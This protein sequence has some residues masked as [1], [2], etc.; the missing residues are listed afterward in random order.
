MIGESAKDGDGLG[1]AAIE[2]VRIGLGHRFEATVGINEL[3][4]GR[5]ERG[6][7]VGECGEDTM[8]RLVVGYIASFN[9][10]Q[11]AQKRQAGRA[12]ATSDDRYQREALILYMSGKGFVVFHLLPG[13]Y[14]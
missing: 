6:V 3:P 9:P 14:A 1:G 2:I 5:R 8:K 4:Q 7:G 12:A 11:T 13:T 10:V